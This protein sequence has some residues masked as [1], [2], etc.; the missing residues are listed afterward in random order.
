MKQFLVATLTF[1]TALSSIWANL[2]DGSD[3]IENRYGN[4][5]QRQLRD[6]ETVSV[7]YHKDRYLYLVIFA[8]DRSVSESYSH[9]NGTDLSE[10]E[11]ANFLKVNAAGATWIPANTSKERRFKRSDDRAEATYG[12]SSGRRGLTVRERGRHSDQ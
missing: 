7:L 6:D 5:V 3:R 1:V 10:K 12:S 2:G 8:N 4:L 9:I 11:I